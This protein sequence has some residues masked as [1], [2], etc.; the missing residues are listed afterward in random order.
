MSLGIQFT[1]SLPHCVVNEPL[2][3]FPS[4]GA[5]FVQSNTA[6]TSV[7]A[8]LRSQNKAKPKFIYPILRIEILRIAESSAIFRHCERAKRVW[9]SKKNV[10]FSEVKYFKNFK[11]KR[12]FAYGS[13]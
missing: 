5:N 6:I 8:S 9:Q 3:L 2:V 13:E 12:F 4:N 1:R 7:V 11:Q 10:I